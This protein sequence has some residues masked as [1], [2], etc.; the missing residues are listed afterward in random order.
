MFLIL[1]LPRGLGD[2]V[3]GGEGV[4]SDGARDIVCLGGR[5]IIMCKHFCFDCILNISWTSS[6]GSSFS[7]RV[8]ISALR[9]YL[10]RLLYGMLTFHNMSLSEEISSNSGIFLIL[11]RSL[12]LAIVSVLMTLT[13]NTCW[14]GSSPWTR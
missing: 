1:Y 12:R 3:R 5:S 4:C 11:I 7:P 10:W 13:S 2:G 14:V 6:R 9:L 8:L